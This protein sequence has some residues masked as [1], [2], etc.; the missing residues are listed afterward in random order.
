MRIISRNIWVLSLISLCTDL[1]SEMLYPVLPLYLQYAGYTA[2]FIGILEGV[3]EATAGLSKSYFGQL[4]DISGH[5]LPFVRLGYSFSAISKPMLA[6]LAHPLWI[7]LSRTLDRLGKGIRTGARDALLSDESEKRNKGTVFGFHRALDS[8]GAVLGPAMALWYLYHHPN[9]YQTLFL[10]AFLP[11]L[12]SVFLT[13]FIREKPKKSKSRRH[14]KSLFAFAHYWK[15]APRNFKKLCIGL[16][17]FSLFNSSDAF[18]LLR[19]KENGLDNYE[20]IG[21]YIFYNLV[22][23]VFSYPLGRLADKLGLKRVMLGGILLY[24]LVYSGFALGNGVVLYLLLFLLYGIYAASTESIAK[25][26]ISNM[27]SEEDTATAI[28]TYSGF[29]SLS[30]LIASSLC[31]ILWIS[32]GAKTT[33]LITAIMSLVTFLYLLLM[34][35]NNEA[36]EI[37]IESEP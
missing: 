12:L 18:L 32:A 9:D 31:G 35:S 10:L 23:S 19:M 7:F 13:F 27:V 5:R 8:F 28:G 29:Q 14:R 3:A 33:F 30:A 4:S 2:L 20:V 22:Y 37:N 6:V 25:A 17:L 24:S 16:L 21:V 11:G 26:W 36:Q 15:R 1:A 34:T